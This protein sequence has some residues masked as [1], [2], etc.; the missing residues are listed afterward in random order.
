VSASR[1]GSWVAAIAA[2]G[3]AAAGLAAC[4]SITSSPSP[5]A[6]HSAAQRTWVES[7][8]RFVAGLQVE[9]LSSQNGGADLASARRAIANENDIYT[10]L[11]DYTDFGDCN[12]ELG[13]IGVPA[14]GTG[15]VVA[16]IISACGRLEHAA[17]LFQNAMTYNR[18]AKLLAATLLAAKAAP[19]LAEAED[20]LAKLSSN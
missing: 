4:G 3:L 6:A 7:A 11:V 12:R 8:G 5:P 19:L 15:K 13:N 14:A 18:P 9:I 1:A 17:S 16:L 2:G 20:G 10:M